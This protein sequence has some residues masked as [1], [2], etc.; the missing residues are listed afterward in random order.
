MTKRTRRPRS[1]QLYVVVVSVQSARRGVQTLRMQFVSLDTA[2]E[3]IHEA[4]K[5]SYVISAEL[6][7]PTT[8]WGTAD[9]AMYAMTHAL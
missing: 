6:D 7:V 9:V 1:K 2:R 5:Q 4:R 8:I 3:F